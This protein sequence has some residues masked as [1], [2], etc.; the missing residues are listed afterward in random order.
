MRTLPSRG[1]DRP[2]DAPTSDDAARV[3]PSDGDAVSG[4]VRRRSVNA[5]PRCSLQTTT[6]RRRGS[7]TVSTPSTS[8]SMRPAWRCC[9]PPDWPC[10]RRRAGGPGPVRATGRLTSWWW[11]RSTDR[12]TQR[13]GCRGAPP[14][15]AWSATVFRRLRWWRT[16]EPAIRYS[17]VRGAGAQHNGH[18]IHV[19]PGRSLTDCDHRRQRSAADVVPP[20]AVPIDGRDGAR[21]R[22][23][24]RRAWIRRVDRLRRRPDRRMGL[25]GRRHDSRPRP[26]AWPPTRW[27]AT[28]SRSITGHAVGR[29]PRPRSRCSTSCSRRP[30]P[31][32]AQPSSGANRSTPLPS[33]SWTV[34]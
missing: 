24:R 28:W 8:T 5:P 31:A 12:P 27:V 11:T 16:C 30:A 19:G 33:G 13:W 10:C 17:A 9:T 25:P 2:N 34:A 3:D 15:C 1:V 4:A 7:A 14:H 32:E 21:H 18:P 20:G 6:G 22:V 23:G 29:S 26:A